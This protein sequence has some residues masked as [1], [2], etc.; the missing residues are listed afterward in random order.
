MA[1][2]RFPYTIIGPRAA[3][4][5]RIRSRFRHAVEGRHL[6]MFTHHKPLTYAFNQNL[7]QCSPRQFRH[8]DYIGHFT[9]DV[10]YITELDN[11]VADELSRIEAIAKSVD[12]QSLAAAQEIDTESRDIVN[13]GKSAL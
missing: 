3:K 13:S 4:I 8:F 1:A 10:R 11:N 6:V 7:N 9:T 2:I 12:H 5:Q